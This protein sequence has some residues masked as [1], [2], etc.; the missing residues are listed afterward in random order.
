MPRPVVRCSVMSCHVV[1]TW[2][3]GSAS[4]SGDGPAACNVSEKS[5]NFKR[6]AGKLV[7]ELWAAL[8][9]K[10]SAEDVRVM[11]ATLSRAV[12]RQG[13]AEYIQLFLCNNQLNSCSFPF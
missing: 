9:S 5:N 4:S 2:S 3:A 13:P 12:T 7:G 10:T 8:E 1:T 6:M 11:C